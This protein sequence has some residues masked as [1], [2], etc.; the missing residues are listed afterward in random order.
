MTD[1]RVEPLRDYANFRDSIRDFHSWL[2]PV[3][4][5]ATDIDFFCERNG[6]FLFIEAK[7]KEKWGIS[8]PYGQHL[9]LYRLS[10]QPNTT[11]WVVGESRDTM[12]LVDYAT[13]IPPKFIRPKG[14]STAL[15]EP[16]VL[17]EITKEGLQERAAEWWEAQEG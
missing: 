13:R 2:G 8:L 14:R 17:Q 5:G 9:A 1:T 3:V 15:W 11:L 12:Y 7:P 10:Q 4:S 6:G 16:H